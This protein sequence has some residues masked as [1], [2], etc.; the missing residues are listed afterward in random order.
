MEGYLFGR[1]V[2]RT[3]L[4]IYIITVRMA[5]ATSRTTRYSTR[6]S[7]TPSDGFV[8]LGGK[9]PIFCFCILL[10]AQGIHSIDD[11]VCAASYSSKSRQIVASWNAKLFSL[12]RRYPG[13]VSSLRTRLPTRIPFEPFVLGN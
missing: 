2:F 6:V 10:R 5:S 9:R 1:F 8:C 4:K 3:L 13:N 12:R 7:L 11:G